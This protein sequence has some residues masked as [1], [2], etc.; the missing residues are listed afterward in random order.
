MTALNKRG[1]HPRPL[2][3]NEGYEVGWVRS[4]PFFNQPLPLLADGSRAPLPG[5]NPTN[6]FPWVSRGYSIVIPVS[7]N[8]NTPLLLEDNWRNLLI[9]QNNSV[10]TSPDTAPNLFI[11][12]DGPVQSITV[13]TASFPYNA[14]SLAPGEGLLLDTRILGNAL[15]FAWG[16]FSNGGGTAVVF[17]MCLYGRTLNSPPLA[18]SAPAGLKHFTTA[19]EFARHSGR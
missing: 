6:E 14:L 1:G 11:A 17:G 9:L 16:A 18:Q 15:Y 4:W 19:Q 10:A 7:V 13:G 8:P 2:I 12:L 3:A 5:Q